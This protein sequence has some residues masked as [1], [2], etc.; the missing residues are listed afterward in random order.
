[1]RTFI[2]EVLGQGDNEAST[3]LSKS[4]EFFLALTKQGMSAA[5]VT[6]RGTQDWLAPDGTQCRVTFLD[7]NTF[8]GVANTIDSYS[9]LIAI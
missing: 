4:P 5:Q 7:A 1:M 9:F 6:R 2:L 3:I 8:L